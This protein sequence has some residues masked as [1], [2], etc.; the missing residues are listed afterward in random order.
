MASWGL[1]SRAML[2]RS[3]L[4]VTSRPLSRVH[5]RCL[6][7][8]LSRPLLRDE[9]PKERA[10]SRGAKTQS[11]FNL[12]DL[13]QGRLPTKKLE[14]LAEDDGPAYPTVLQQHRNNMLK[15]PHCVVLTRV[16]NF[17]EMYFNQA[18]EFAPLL[19]LKLGRKN[20]NAGPVPMAG[21][22]FFQIDKFL[23]VLVQDLHRYVAL[24]DEFAVNPEDRAK[25]GGNLFDRKITR[26]ITPGTLIDEKFMDPLSNNFLLSIT[27]DLTPLQGRGEQGQ[28]GTGDSIA[29]SLGLA[30]VDLSSGDFFTQQAD[31]AALSSTVARIGPREIVVDSRMQD[32]KVS[33]LA[34]LLKE[35][36]HV[37]TYHRAP[38]GAADAADW[39]P[40]L[41]EKAGAVDSKKFS[42]LELDAGNLLMHYVKTQL[43]G[44]KPMLEA[45]IHRETDEFMAI[46]RNTLKVLE[47]RTTLRDGSF[48][49]S[50]LHAVA[51]TVTKSGSRL[52]R[53][54]LTSPSMSIAEINDR[55]DLVTELRDHPVLMENLITLLQQ[56]FDSLRL[57]QKFTFGRGDADDLIGLSKTIQVTRQLAELLQF[58]GELPAEAGST[59]LLPGRACIRRLHGRLHLAEPI[60]LS[61][62]IL[63][64]IDEDK[65]MEQHE[66]ENSEAAA[67]AGLAADVLEEEGEEPVKRLTK[68]NK[69][70]MA[71]T[72]ASSKDDVENSVWI[73]RR[74]ATPQLGRLHGLL[75]NLR[76]Q[77]A[78]LEA[79]LKQQFNVPS[80]SLKWTPG[81]GHI[82][83]VKG[84]DVKA[85]M[86][87]ME[88]ARTV[89]A[90]KSTQSFY[91]PEWTRL[92]QTV[93]GAKLKIQNEEQRLFSELRQ[94]VVRNL[95][96]LRRNASVLD[97]LDVACSFARLAKEQDLVR[98]IVNLGTTTTIF[99]GRHPVVEAGLTEQGRQFSA[100][101]LSVGDDRRILLITGPNMGGKS[102]FLRQNALISILA[103]T[104]SFVPVDYAEIGL[105]DKIFSRV[106]SADNLYQDQST[107]M[108]EMLETADILNQATERSFVIMDEVGRGTTPEDGTAVGYACLDHL[109]RINKCRTLFAT[110]FHILTDMTETWDEVACYHTDVA[111]KEDGSF[112]YIHRLEPGVN[113]KSHALKVARLAGI[114]EE[115]IQVAESVLKTLKSSV[116]KSTEEANVANDRESTENEPMRQASA[117]NL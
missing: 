41:E 84:K 13:P 35:E 100:N 2:S 115:T 71:E 38:A 45:P 24:S 64:A 113:R 32:L 102:T 87:T 77:K 108:V 14:P 106:G 92:G 104:G 109:R 103:Q 72:A 47:I 50:L 85:A 3:H 39:A 49:G 53:E 91:L 60:E 52:L 59:D 26:I 57:V 16:G 27:T 94:Q 96:K 42:Q 40:M 83:H 65:V 46:D 117:S 101:D 6:S 36:Y 12:D 30:W 19:N 116:A 112:S 8:R 48:E 25:S 44:T 63:D 29:E 5:S 75:D 111:E 15:F 82:C 1:N 86:A 31:T 70:K 21:F 110:H 34:P 61:E 93:D 9:S 105:V 78:A 76:D 69:T 18:E 43:Q 99:G 17:Y 89:R 4:E 33:P 114:P 107:F 22:P 67:I 51:R 58:H 23:K 20:T 28:S 74:S 7:T 56:T 95:V 10:W 68:A 66:F 79:K 88:G 62:R 11:S 54:R 55:L 80:L 37:I 98:P 90:S 81:L 97:E 73:M